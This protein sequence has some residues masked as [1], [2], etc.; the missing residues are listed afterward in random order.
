M[1]EY[2]NYTAVPGAVSARDVEVYALSTCGFCK[3]AL[4]F[5]KDQGIA[6][7]YVH[8][9]LMPFETKERVKKDLADRFH[10]HISFPYAVVDG[11]VTLIGFIEADWRRKL[12]DSKD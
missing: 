8:I 3:R 5:L 7:R 10:E 4:A 1:L 9:D 11:R 6:Y 2:I 12:V